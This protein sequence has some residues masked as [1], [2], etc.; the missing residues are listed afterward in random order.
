MKLFASVIMT[1]CTLLGTAEIARAEDPMRDVTVDI[2]PDT[3]PKPLPVIAPKPAR[4]Q[5]CD[6]KGEH[7]GPTKVLHHA[8]IHPKHK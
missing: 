4:V 8:P 1:A 3:P 7:C 5:V 2:T 6:G